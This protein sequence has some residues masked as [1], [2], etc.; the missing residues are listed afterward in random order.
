MM[1]E[2]VVKRLQKRKNAIRNRKNDCEKEPFY[3]GR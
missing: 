2:E 3:V 1:N